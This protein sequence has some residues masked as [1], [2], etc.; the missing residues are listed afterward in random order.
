MT[1]E[2]TYRITRIE[3]DKSRILVG[4]TPDLCEIGVMIHEDRDKYDS[5]EDCYEVIRVDAEEEEYEQ[6]GMAQGAS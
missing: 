2:K 6:G 1:R 4:F 5:E 3:K